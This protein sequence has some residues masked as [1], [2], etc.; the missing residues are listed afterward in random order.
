[1]ARE[2]NFLLG[3]GERLVSKVKVPKSSGPKNLP[4][5]LA[6]DKTRIARKKRSK[7]VYFCSDGLPDQLQGT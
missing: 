4:Y 2:H 1:M 7:I 5:D 3:Q 6:T